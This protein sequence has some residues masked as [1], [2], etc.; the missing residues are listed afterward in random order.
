MSLSDFK[1]VLKTVMLPALQ[2]INRKIT[3]DAIIAVVAHKKKYIVRQPVHGLIHACRQAIISIYYAHLT[4]NQID[5]D[6]GKDLLARI[7]LTSLG[8]YQESNR[9]IQHNRRDIAMIRELFKNVLNEEAS[10]Q[11]L[12]SVLD[13]DDSFITKCVNIGKLME[14]RRIVSDSNNDQLLPLLSDETVNKLILLSDRMLFATGD[15]NPTMGRVVYLPSFG[16][17][18][19]DPEE[20][21]VAISLAVRA[22]II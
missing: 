3:N 1:E 21:N 12:L 11:F 20:L 8:Q 13:E 14:T 2:Y 4:S 10:D 15:K 16:V 7:F 6:C 18:S 9:C 19:N 17:L 22:H 5:C